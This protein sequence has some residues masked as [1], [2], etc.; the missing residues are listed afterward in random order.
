MK[1]VLNM[2]KVR[3]TLLHEPDIDDSFIVGLDCTNDLEMRLADI[4]GKIR[5][6]KSLGELSQQFSA[7]DLIALRNEEFTKIYCSLEG[8][9]ND[10]ERFNIK[11][12][13]FIPSVSM[14]RIF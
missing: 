11:R 7:Q 2:E 4:Y 10:G 5:N 12:V 14:R 3:E 6:S 1:T 9:Y 13:N 8:I